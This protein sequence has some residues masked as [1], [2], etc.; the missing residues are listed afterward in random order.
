MSYKLFREQEDG[1]V[2][3]SLSTAESGRFA[4]LE[5]GGSEDD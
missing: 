3:E 4:A 2:E 5:K 1:L